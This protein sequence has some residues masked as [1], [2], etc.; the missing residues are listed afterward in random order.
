MHAGKDDTA[1]RQVFTQLGSSN[2]RPVTIITDFDG[3]MHT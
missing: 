1:Q 3:H 2:V